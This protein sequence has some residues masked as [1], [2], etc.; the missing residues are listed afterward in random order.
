MVTISGFT[1]RAVTELMCV[2]VCVCVYIYIYIYIHI[3]SLYT[4]LSSTKVI[5]L[6]R[7]SFLLFI[8]SF[9]L[10]LSGNISTKSFL[11]FFRYYYLFLLFLIICLYPF[12]LSYVFSLSLL[13][14]VLYYVILNVSLSHYSFFLLMFVSLFLSNFPRPAKKHYR[15]SVILTMIRDLNSS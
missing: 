12:F 15:H 6:L 4:Q 2:C 13:P 10:F 1:L 11:L 5:S 7:S 14:S 3:Y 8:P 9:S